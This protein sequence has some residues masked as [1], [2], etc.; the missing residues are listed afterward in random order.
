MQKYLHISDYR[1]NDNTYKTVNRVLQSNMY[2]QITIN[3]IKVDLSILE[4]VDF[5]KYNGDQEELLLEIVERIVDR[6]EGGNIYII[7]FLENI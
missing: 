6:L 5:H 7:G 1:F 4:N 2:I 3:I